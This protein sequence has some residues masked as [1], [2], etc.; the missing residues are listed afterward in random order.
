MATDF[1]TD[2]DCAFGLSPSFQL[3]TG[4]T[5]LAQA[6]MRRLTTPRGG[7]WYDPNYGFDLRIL[8]GATLTNSQL[9]ALSGMI[10][11]EC[12]KD[13]R[14]S[15]ARCALTLANGRMTVAITVTTRTGAFDLTLGVSDVTVELL[16]VQAV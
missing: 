6:L 8:V 4:N 10:E 5:L 9:G 14:V 1:G 11:V 3:V 16:K 13:D 12:E 15:S 7:L 2:I